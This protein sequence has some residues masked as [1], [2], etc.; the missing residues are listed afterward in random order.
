M[1]TSRASATAFKNVA[2]TV[3]KNESSGIFRWGNNGSNNNVE[4]GNNV[5]LCN[6]GW[7]DKGDPSVSSKLCNSDWLDQVISKLSF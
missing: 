1:G 2:T 4:L 7:L 5:G 6:S 3:S